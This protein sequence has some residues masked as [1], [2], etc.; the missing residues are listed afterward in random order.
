LDKTTLAQLT[1]GERMVELLK[2]GQFQP[3]SVEKQI[4]VIFL[5]V[6]GYLDAVPTSQISRLQQEFLSYLESSYPQVQKDI[7]EKKQI[8]DSLRATLI[9][10]AD[11]FIQGFA[12]KAEAK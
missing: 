12:A 10:A 11:E 2:Q 3:L 7:V 8:D 9:K 4:A 5:G 6:N 1:R